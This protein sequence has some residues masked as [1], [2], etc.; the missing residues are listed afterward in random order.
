MACGCTVPDVAG[1][2]TVDEVAAMAIYVAGELSSAANGAAL[3]VDAA[4]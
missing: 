4:S 2:A 3:Q 1:T